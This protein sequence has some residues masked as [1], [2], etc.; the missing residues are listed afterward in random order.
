[1]GDGLEPFVNPILAWL[2]VFCLVVAIAL[3]LL[4]GDA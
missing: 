1:V 3:V 2:L 4:I